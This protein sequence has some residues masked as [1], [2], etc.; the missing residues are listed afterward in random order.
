MRFTEEDIRDKAYLESEVE[1]EADK[2]FNSKLPGARRGRSLDEIK[3]AVR[4]GK[5]A[6]VYLIENA[7]YLACPNSY[8]DL[9]DSEG[10]FIEVK[11]YKLSNAHSE[12]EPIKKE[13]ERIKKSKWNK[14]KWMIIFSCEGG[15]YNFI[16]KV[17]I[18]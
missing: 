1:W 10:N 3:S 12:S 5:I 11:A 7:G 18:K 9:Q 6:E 2:I 16:E 17:E 14:S 15:V 13:I 4:Q 8:H